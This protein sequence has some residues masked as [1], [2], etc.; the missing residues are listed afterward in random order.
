MAHHSEGGHSHSHANPGH[1]VPFHVYATVLGVLLVLTV[2][3]VAISRIDFGSWNIIVAMLIASVKAGTVALFFMHL[4]YENPLV[5]LYVVFPVVLV[6]IMLGGIFI[7]NPFRTYPQIHSE[8]HAAK[9]AGAGGGE[10][11]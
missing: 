7:D 2:I 4:K 11:H 10:H 3:T 6:F 9:P 5:W 1:I 8:E